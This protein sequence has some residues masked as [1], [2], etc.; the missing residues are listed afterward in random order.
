M[1]AGQFVGIIIALAIIA[2]GVISI[3]VDIRGLREEQLDWIDYLKRKGD[4]P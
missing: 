1:D 2:G 3:A 4:L